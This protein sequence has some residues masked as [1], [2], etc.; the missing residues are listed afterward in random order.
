M[1]QVSTDSSYHFWPNHFNLILVAQ[2]RVGLFGDVWGLG[3]KGQ[4]LRV[5]DC[6]RAVE[7][8]GLGV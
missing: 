8:L 2:L 3:L 7:G 5:E 1:Y 4:Q 6:E